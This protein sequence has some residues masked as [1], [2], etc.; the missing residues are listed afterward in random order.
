[1]PIETYKNNNKPVGLTFLGRNHTPETRK[2][3]SESAKKAGT[4]NWMKGKTPHIN[5]RIGASIKNK[6]RKRP[7]LAERN[8]TEWMRKISVANGLSRKGI[9]LSEQ[10]KENMRKAQL[11]RKHP[12]EV[13][14]KIGLAHKGEKCC[15][16]K[17]G[18]TKKHDLIRCSLEYD[19]WRVSIFERDDF[20]CQMPGCGIR[21]GKLEAHHIKLFSEFPEL[22]FDKN[23]GI[24][25]CEFHHKK[26]KN[27]E[28]QF[29]NLFTEITKCQK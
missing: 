6:G 9:K 15:F 2:K 11:G 10:A 7:D 19:S 17:G 20:T 22:I 29:E 21:G 18:I 14:R 12:I 3:M 28:K 16:W 4:G 13:K 24:T 25:L 5:C 8:K 26:I 1:M 23:N 27:K